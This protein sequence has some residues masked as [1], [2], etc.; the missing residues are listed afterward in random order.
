MRDCF[1]VRLVLR[2]R[3]EPPESDRSCFELRGRADHTLRRVIRGMPPAAGRA[4]ETARVRDEQ[5]RIRRHQARRGLAG[6]SQS[7]PARRRRRQRHPRWWYR[8]GYVDSGVAVMI[9]YPAVSG[10]TSSTEATATT[11][12]PAASTTTSSSAAPGATRCLGA[13]AMTGS[14]AV[15]GGTGWMAAA[16]M[17]AWPAA[18]TTIPLP[19]GPGATRWT[20]AT[21]T[22]GSSMRAART[23]WGGMGHDTFV[24]AAIHQLSTGGARDAILDFALGQDRI[25]LTAVDADLTL[26]GLNAFNAL[27]PGHQTFSAPGQ[28]R[29]DSATGILSGNVDQDLEAE[30]EILFANAPR[31]LGLALPAFPPIL[32]PTAPSPP[33]ASSPQPTDERL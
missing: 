23:G 31:D 8:A 9:D 29:Y 17:T 30:F 4:G 7:A 12:W 28:L 20:E 2:T 19:A 1:N 21:A 18:S 13:T 24:L 14:P 11:A 16:A 26:P 27:L 6:R 15:S 22:T 10:A 3:T 25:D 32:P 5:L 33:A